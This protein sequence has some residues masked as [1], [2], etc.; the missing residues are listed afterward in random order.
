MNLIGGAQS[1]AI[2]K[3]PLELRKCCGPKLPELLE[4]KL[5]DPEKQKKTGDNCIIV[6]VILMI[7]I[8]AMIMITM[9]LILMIVIIIIKVRITR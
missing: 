4:L 7:I 3:T 9:T 8:I 5:E 6:V 2:L 1:S